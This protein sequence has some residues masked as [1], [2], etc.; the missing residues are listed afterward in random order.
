[1]TFGSILVPPVGLGDVTFPQVNNGKSDVSQS[2]EVYQ[3]RPHCVLQADQKRWSMEIQTEHRNTDNERRRESTPTFLGDVRSQ[4][5][6]FQKLNP[7]P[8][9]YKT[10]FI[11]CSDLQSC[12][13][14]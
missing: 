10:V 1:M 6:G 3:N 14:D 9:K 4:G 11:D 2:N 8:A 12:I 7:T 13:H 5:Y